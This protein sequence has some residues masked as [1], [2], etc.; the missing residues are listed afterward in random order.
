MF[1]SNYLPNTYVISMPFCGCKNKANQ[2][3]FYGEPVEPSKPNEPKFSA[4]TIYPNLPF[5]NCFV[6]VKRQI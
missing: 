4:L 1:T 3:Q 6:F 5:Y 2:T